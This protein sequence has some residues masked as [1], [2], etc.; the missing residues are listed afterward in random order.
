MENSSTTIPYERFTQLKGN[1]RCDSE[2][3]KSGARYIIV[4]NLKRLVE[5]ALKDIK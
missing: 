2:P 1:C 5:N 3:P 4:R